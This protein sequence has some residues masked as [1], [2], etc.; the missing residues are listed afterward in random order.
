MVKREAEIHCRAQNWVSRSN[1]DDFRHPTCTYHKVFEKI[2]KKHGE[3]Y[4]WFLIKKLDHNSGLH[5]KNQREINKNEVRSPP[6]SA[7]VKNVEIPLLYS[8]PNSDQS[9]EC[10][11]TLPV[12]LGELNS[13][14]GR[15]NMKFIKNT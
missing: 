8:G 10:D 1:V 12:D 14:G 2:R 11:I 5:A 15:N 9:H 7:F 13:G 4:F 6:P 3:N